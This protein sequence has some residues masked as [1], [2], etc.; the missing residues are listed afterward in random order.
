[1]TDAFILGSRNAEQVVVFYDPELLC[2]FERCYGKVKEIL[3][4][5]IASFSWL[6]P[7]FVYSLGEQKC[8][9]VDAYED[10]FRE[11]CDID[12]LVNGT[13]NVVL[14]GRNHVVRS[15]LHCR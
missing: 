12:N 15:Q 2:L 6:E 5:R 9:E 1:M 11:L 4:K 7:V 10:C 13:L 14:L 3:L 8:F